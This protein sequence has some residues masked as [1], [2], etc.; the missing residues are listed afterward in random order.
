MSA[1]DRLPKVNTAAG[2]LLGGGREEL[3]GS[4]DFSQVTWRKSSWSA[5]NGNCLEFAELHGGLVGVRDTKD[6]GQGPVLVFD[7]AA[8][9]SFI[10]GVK[11]GA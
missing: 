1:G 3:P 4:A 9:R 8:W 6:D 10:H 5:M 11:R 7:S 2:A